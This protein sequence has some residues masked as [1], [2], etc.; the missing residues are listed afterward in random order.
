[1]EK[2][3]SKNL[4][5]GFMGLLGITWLVFQSNCQ[6]KVS[7][8]KSQIDS[9][10]SIYV[11][12][13]IAKYPFLNK[14]WRVDYMSGDS[15]LCELSFTKEDKDTLFR[16]TIERFMNDETCVSNFKILD[17]KRAVKIGGYIVTTRFDE[18]LIALY[19]YKT[20]VE[21]DDE[22]DKD[23]IFGWYEFLME[24]HELDQGQQ[25]FLMDHRDSLRRVK[26][27]DLPKLPK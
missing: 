16:F 5:Q 4:V 21:D 18:N 7:E 3:Q 13:A 24:K 22:I 6:Q 9:P 14:N 20:K 1:M 12:E 27:F 11:S 26:G 2:M 23:F 25:F 15:I 17:F 10:S 19:Q 8:E